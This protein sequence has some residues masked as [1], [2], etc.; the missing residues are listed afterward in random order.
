MMSLYI[1]WNICQYRQTNYHIFGFYAQF[2]LSN[3]GGFYSKKD[4]ISEEN[5]SP[6]SD[7]FYFL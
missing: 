4:L 6:N 2:Y 1:I 3:F 7:P 5:H